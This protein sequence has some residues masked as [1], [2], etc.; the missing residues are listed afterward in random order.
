MKIYKITKYANRRLYDHQDHRYVNLK[1]IRGLIKR[2]ENIE[3]KSQ[4]AGTNITTKILLQILIL[5]SA[6]GYLDIQ[7]SEMVY[8]IREGIVDF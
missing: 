3:V 5:M 6:N 7:D 2:G 8:A 4:K 1:E